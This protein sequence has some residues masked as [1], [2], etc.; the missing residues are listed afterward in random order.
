MKKLVNNIRVYF[1]KWELKRNPFT[2]SGYENRM[3]RIIGTRFLNDWEV[4]IVHKLKQEGRIKPHSIWRVKSPNSG[5]TYTD[6]CY[7]LK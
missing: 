6:Q 2:I 5:E 3:V 7:I 4:D 1:L